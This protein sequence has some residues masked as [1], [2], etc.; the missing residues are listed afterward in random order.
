MEFQS[1]SG[2]CAM[3]NYRKSNLPPEVAV[4]INGDI[5]ECEFCRTNFELKCK[6]PKRVQVKLISTK[7]KA[8]YRGNY[9]PDLLKN[10][11]AS[12]K[13]RRMLQNDD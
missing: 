13:L 2:A 6:I 5:V 8:D 11:R 4:G 7:K 1:K 9:N 12:A 3:F 10:K